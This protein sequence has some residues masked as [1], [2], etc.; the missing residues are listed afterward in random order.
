MINYAL[1]YG[2]T[3]FTLARD[4]GVSKREAEEFIDAYFARYP[5]VRRF[6]D[7]TIARARETGTVRTLLGRLRRL[8]DLHARNFQVRAEAE[9]QAMNTPVQGSAADLIKK[10]MIDLDG[11]LRRRGLATRLVLQIHDELLLEAPEGEAEVA[12]RLVK[13]VMEGALTLDVPLV[14]DARVGRNWG[15]AH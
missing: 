7:E 15:E 12:L 11:A 6:I 8:P 10:A 3:A 5:S 4:I 9:R 13:E 1:L 14:V 2:K